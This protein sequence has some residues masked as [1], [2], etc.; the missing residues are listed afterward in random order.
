MVYNLT[1]KKRIRHKV[2]YEVHTKHLRIKSSR[3]ERFLSV[4]NILNSINTQYRQ[5]EKNINVR[6]SSEET[7][8]QNYWIKGVAGTY[9]LP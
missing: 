9:V 4:N 5:T 6:E 3:K 8:Y 7:R 1:K 2:Y